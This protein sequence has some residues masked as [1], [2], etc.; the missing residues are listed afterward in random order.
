MQQ[1]FPA[2]KE[3]KVIIAQVK[4]DLTVQGWDRTEIAVKADGRVAASG[5]HGHCEG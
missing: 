5:C 1:T 3:P 4:G 2:G